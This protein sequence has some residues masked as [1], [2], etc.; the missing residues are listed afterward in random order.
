MENPEEEL[1]NITGGDVMENKLALAH[2]LVFALNSNQS[3]PERML[4]V[5]QAIILYS[6]SPEFLQHAQRLGIM[7]GICK[8]M[9]RFLPN[10]FIQ[11]QLCRALSAMYPDITEAGRPPAQLASHQPCEQLAV[12]C[13]VRTMKEHL[14][15]IAPHQASM[16]ALGCLTES[17]YNWTAAYCDEVLQEKGLAKAVVTSMRTHQNDF[18]EQL[19][20]LRIIHNMLVPS[21][22]KIA[23]RLWKAGA[24]GAVLSGMDRLLHHLLH[25]DVDAQF[26]SHTRSMFVYCFFAISKLFGYP[27]KSSLEHSE[28]FCGSQVKFRKCEEPSLTVLSRAM[29]KF[30][31]CQDIQRLGAIAMLSACQTEANREIIGIPG[32]KALVRVCEAYLHAEHGD[33]EERFLVSTVVN[34]LTDLVKAS[35]LHCAYLANRSV[36]SCLLSVM[37]FGKD[38]D[39]LVCFVMELLYSM[40]TSGGWDVRHE[41]VKSGCLQAVV[42]AM[43]T[44]KHDVVPGNFGLL[45]EGVAALSA[46]VDG[47][48]PAES[49][50]LV[51]DSGAAAAV[52]HAMDVHLDNPMTQQNG[53]CCL[54][55]IVSYYVTEERMHELPDEAL[56]TI[57]RA[58]F[59]CPG[60]IYLH[61]DA[62]IAI[63]RLLLYEA[64]LEDSNRHWSDKLCEFRGVEALTKCLE[65]CLCTSKASVNASAPATSCENNNTRSD[66]VSHSSSSSS[67]AASAS[68]LSSPAKPTKTAGE[69][70]AG[71]SPSSEIITCFVSREQQIWQRTVGFAYMA[72]SYA[73]GGHESNQSM[74]AQH[75]TI[76]LVLSVMAQHKDNEDLDGHA[77]FCLSAMAQNHAANTEFL[78]RNGGLKRMLRVSHAITEEGFRERFGKIMLGLKRDDCVTKAAIEAIEKAE[79]A[80]GAEACAGC[81]KTRAELGMMQLLKCA[82]CCIE[83]KYCSVKCQKACWPV[84][85]A[86]CKA[87]RK[88]SK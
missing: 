84:H 59:T 43:G 75:G 17:S 79:R 15:D 80:K 38:D 16:M 47:N 10:A 57:I 51:L 67:P 42:T 55:F 58:M 46:I 12:T 30:T 40:G 54:R 53:V 37:R 18:R 50:Q 52:M 49:A 7:E 82:A 25:H 62:V 19:L 66:E 36:L 81:G 8:A 33:P 24:L 60:D 68:S 34:A 72:L 14:M 4:G 2:T 69:N 6:E 61:E 64:T 22:G 31:E 77:C 63:A 86:E 13:L 39:A 20:G 65:L 11:Y 83:P 70:L 76:G 78:A 3:D 88:A 26:Q 71:T 44:H 27:I 73:A 21:S 85:K 29:S 32:I 5:T 48:F 56:K 74:C 28:Y 9:E 45:Q 35:P 1:V 87:N 41:M 23:D